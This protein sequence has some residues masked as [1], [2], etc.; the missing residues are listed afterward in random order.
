M[1]SYEPVRSWYEPRRVPSE[2][3]GLDLR[4]Q[5]PL[6]DFSEVVVEPLRIGEPAIRAVEYLLR[7]H[8]FERAPQR[9][10]RRRAGLEVHVRVAASALS[11][12]NREILQPAMAQN[13]G[14]MTCL[15]TKGGV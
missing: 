11:G 1:R 6:A 2:D 5:V 14:R 8:D 4:S 9:E 10:E 7:S 15:T 13:P 3:S 12:G